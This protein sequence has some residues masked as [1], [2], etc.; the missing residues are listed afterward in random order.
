MNLTRD[1]LACQELHSNTHP[2]SPPTFISESDLDDVI[3]LESAQLTADGG[4]I[5][6]QWQIES[7]FSPYR[8]EQVA[9][10]SRPE[11]A[12][13]CEVQDLADPT[14]LQVALRAPR[15]PAGEQYRFCVT[16][17]ELTPGT[18][19]RI[20]PVCRWAELTAAPALL[21][22]LDEFSAEVNSAGRVTAHMQLSPLEGRPPDDCAIAVVVL[23]PRGPLS[24]VE[25]SCAAPRVTLWAA[26]GAEQVRVCSTDPYRAET[27]LNT[28]RSLDSAAAVTPP[29]PALRRCVEARSKDGAVWWQ[30]AAGVGLVLAVGLLIGWTVLRR[31]RCRCLERHGGRMRLESSD[32]VV[33][34]DVDDV[35]SDVDEETDLPV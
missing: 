26:I 29:S 15:L 33:S 34:D 8:C 24:A 27:P 13:P 28:T 16:L 18:E 4:S 23:G 14:V 2:T 9:L 30:A 1:Q 17:V 31:R 7:H 20:S 3:K 19:L 32:S 12:Q 6:L 21:P 5:R 25:T 10:A 22:Q 35:E 11:S